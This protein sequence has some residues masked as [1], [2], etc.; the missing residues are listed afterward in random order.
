MC[1]RISVV[2]KDERNHTRKSPSGAQRHMKK[3]SERKEEE[4]GLQLK[5]EGNKDRGI[6]SSKMRRSEIISA[7]MHQIR[8]TDGENEPA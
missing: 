6:R 1:A 7:T 2:R 4:R 5:R 8:E 3:G